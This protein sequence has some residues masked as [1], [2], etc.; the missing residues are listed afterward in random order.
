MNTLTMPLGT[1]FEGRI[2]LEAIGLLRTYMKKDGD[3]RQL[4]IYEL[5]TS[6][7]C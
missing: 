4:Y 2:S 3:I 1:V 7:R 6:T 5:L